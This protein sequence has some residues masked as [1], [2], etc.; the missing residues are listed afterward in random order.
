[1][2]QLRSSALGDTSEV[3]SLYFDTPD[4]DVYAERLRKSEGA[5]VVRLR[6]YGQPDAQAPAWLERK[7]H[8]EPWTGERSLKVRFTL[9]LSCCSAALHACGQ[10]H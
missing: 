3:T 4:L 6:W 9:A 7:T 1:M 5:A 2:A 8:H 10:R